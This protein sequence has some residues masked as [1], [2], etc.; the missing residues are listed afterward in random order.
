MNEQVDILIG[1]D[2]YYRIIEGEIKKGNQSDEPIAVNS[3]LGWMLCGSFDG[4][5]QYTST[6]MFSTTDVD[7]TTTSFEVFLGLRINRYN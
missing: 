4:Q 3:K 7:E 2:N 5:Q 1:T 6:A